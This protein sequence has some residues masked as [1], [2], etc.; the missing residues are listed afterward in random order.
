MSSS[1][2]CSEWNVQSLINHNLRVA[3]FAN[4]VLNGAPGIL[5]RCS[6]WRIRYRPKARRPFSWQYRRSAGHRQVHG[7]VIHGGDALRSDARGRFPH[8]SHGRHCYPQL[9]PVH[10]NR[11]EYR[12]GLRLGG[13]VLWVLVPGYRRGPAGRLLWIGDTS[14]D[15]CQHSG[16]ATGHVRTHAVRQ[17]KA[18]FHLPEEWA[19]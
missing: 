4:S 19:Q 9:G 1:T 17:L 8:D 13:S 6:R 15:H 2:P 3:V 16:Q 5:V 14:A 7:Y 12:Y 10:G 11:P 18:R